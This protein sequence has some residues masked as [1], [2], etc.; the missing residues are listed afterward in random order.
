M[1]TLKANH[2]QILAAKPIDGRRT[3][4]RIEGVDGLW[5]HVGPSGR[6]TWYVRYQPGGRKGRVFRQFTIGDAKTVGLQ[7]ATKAA[8]NIVNAVKVDDRDPVAERQAKTREALTFGDVFEDWHA[9]HAM[10]KLARQETDRA[11]YRNHIEPEFAKLRLQDLKRTEIARFRDKVAS[12][13]TPLVSNEV[14]MLIN[15]VLNWALD[16][17]LIDANPAARLRRAGKNR[18]RER[19]LPHQDIHTFWNAL[20]AMETMTGKHVARGEQ[21][22]MFTPATRSILR[23]LL[24][25]GQRRGEVTGALKSELE[26]EGK[27]PVWAIPGERTKNG[28]LHRLPLC[29]LAKAEFAKA[30]A[31]S[32]NSPYVFPSPEAP[33]EQP[34]TP[35]AVTRAM[36]RLVTQL[37]INTVSPHDLRRTVG[38]EM[39]RM[40]LPVHVRALVLN[41]SPQTRGVTDAVYNRYAYDKEK[42]QALHRWEE[43]LRVIVAG[44]HGSL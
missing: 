30:V 41:H 11:Y 39:A 33:R 32:G 36:N 31:A 2:R 4:Y 6:R 5:L 19:V 35:M 9:R 8:H 44:R 26:L 25:T 34:I 10:P 7:K 42:R 16:E 24:L 21:G 38:T 20:A 3:R 23:L 17:G 43:R 12:K 14:L 27:E 40:G 18:P 1:P 22:R 37:K 13:A 29:P 15:R 28:L